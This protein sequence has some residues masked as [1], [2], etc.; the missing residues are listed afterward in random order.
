M[1]PSVPQLD[2]VG[3]LHLQHGLG[4]VVGA[5]GSGI[6]RGGAISNLVGAV[7][8]PFLSHRL[9]HLSTDP[10]EVGVIWRDTLVVAPW[11]QNE[12]AVAVERQIRLENMKAMTG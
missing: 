4:P 9:A 7:G 11:I 6:Q 8:T 12:L 10:L 5:T 3:V 1:L 2:S